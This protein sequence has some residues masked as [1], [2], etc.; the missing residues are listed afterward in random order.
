MREFFENKKIILI[1]SIVVIVISLLVGIIIF[2]LNYIPETKLKFEGVEIRVYEEKYLSELI[3]DNNIKVLKDYQI[4]TKKLGHQEIKFIFTE[5]NKKYKGKIDIFVIDDISPKIFA[6]SSY[7]V[8]KGTEKDFINSIICGDNYDDN[9]TRKIIG[10]YDINKEGT[11]NLT[12]YAKDSSGNES[13]KDFK[14]KVIAKQKTTQTSTKKVY[15]SEIIEKQKNENTEIGIDVSKWQGEIDFDKVKKSGCEFVIIRLGYQ[16]GID[17]EMIIDPYYKQNIQK[18]KEANLKVGVYVY[19]Y[20]KSKEEAVNQANWA[21]QNI[22]PYQLELG[23]S[24]DWESWTLFNK[25]NLSFYNF[26]DV[27]NTFLDYVEENGYKGMLYSSKNYLENIW[28]ATSH[29]I[30]LAHYTT[31]TDYKGKYNM[32]Q[33]TSSG[34]I[35]GIKGAVDINILYK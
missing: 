4:N 21:L 9:P 14:V 19:T 12:Y 15:F 2:Y 8:V 6:S 13:T 17:G 35:D 34:R 11:Y 23:I 29:N 1:I 5:E 10:K 16:K 18:A 32:W 3:N 20:A 28:W 24:Y 7:T 30:W 25:L 31:K 27:A 33:M 22:G 26:T